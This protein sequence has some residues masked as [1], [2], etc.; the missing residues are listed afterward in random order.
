[1]RADLS[2]ELKIR[3]KPCSHFFTL[4][5]FVLLAGCA[6]GSAPDTVFGADSSI[7][8]ADVV[9]TREIG[10]QA[11]LDD[12]LLFAAEN[13]PELRSAFGEWKAA[14]ERISQVMSLPD[15]DL[16]FGFYVRHMDTRQMVGLSQVFPW[17]G[18]LDLAGGVAEKEAQVAAARVEAEKLKLF[19]E[20]RTIYA[21]LAYLEHA[22][23]IS[24]ENQQLLNQF[25][26]IALVRFRTGEV[27]EADVLRAQ[28]EIERLADQVRTL[29][30][31]RDPL[32]AELNA[33]LG[34]TA[35]MELPSAKLPD[36]NG[37]SIDYSGR[38]FSELLAG[39]P[40]LRAAEHR[41]SRGELGVELARK[42]SRPDITIG[43]E[44][45]DN[46]QMRDEVMLMASVNLPIRR[47]RYAAAR[48]E[49]Q[50][51]LETGE[52]AHEALFRELEVELRLTLFRLNDAKRKI[53]LYSEN[54]LP[55]ARQTVANLE[56]S[57]R[58][59][60]ADFFDLIIGQ[61]ALLEIEL[62]RERAIADRFQQEALL[63]E[64]I[65]FSETKGNE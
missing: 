59:G 22:I 13:N 47:E 50:A 23:R 31:T 12:L 25:E 8:R 45:S 18:K 44:F 62:N 55:R 24:G 56:G 17:F 42:E 48:R 26:Q 43:V 61:Q 27:G 63:E 64:L 20:I 32:R 60:R 21:E 38:S 14:V 4:I 51:V 41:V 3:M 46:R 11:T 33:A 54:L 52:A 49:A 19:R 39:N 15:P 7:D 53:D 29:E 16:T 5:V 6:T 28:M 30:E 58:A 9:L 2:F 34:R 10:D 35:E 40:R 37:R 36:E 57:Y 1:M 65:G